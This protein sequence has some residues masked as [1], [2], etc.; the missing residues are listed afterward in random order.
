[1]TLPKTLP[2]SFEVTQ[3]VCSQLVELIVWYDNMPEGL[4]L[5]DS[6]HEDMYERKSALFYDQEIVLPENM[7]LID[8][9]Y[10]EDTCQLYATILNENEDGD[11][12]IDIPIKVE[13]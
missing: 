11:E 4:C 5:R 13:K 6:F 10:N 9:H 1:M 12:E 3:E 8:L 2:T 7:F